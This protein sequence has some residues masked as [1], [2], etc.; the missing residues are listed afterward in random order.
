MAPRLVRKA[1]VAEFARVICVMN[2]A[3]VVRAAG[4]GY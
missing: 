4:I 3:A 2:L 1:E